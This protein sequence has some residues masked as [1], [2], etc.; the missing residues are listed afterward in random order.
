[1]HRWRRDA[2]KAAF[3]RK[4]QNR[5]NN[6]DLQINVAAIYFLFQKG[7]LFICHGHGDLSKKLRII[8]SEIFER[9]IIIVIIF[10]NDKLTIATRY[11]TRIWADAQRD[12]RSA[13]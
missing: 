4:K 12:G 5:K 7:L 9:S 13:E 10:F 8:F 3:P 6:A 2:E 11:K 1:M